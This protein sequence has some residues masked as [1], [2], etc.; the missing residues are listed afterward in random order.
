MPAPRS[1]AT[2]AAGSRRAVVGR[3]VSA[4]RSTYSLR[5]GAKTPW[6]GW[7]R[8]PSAGALEVTPPHQGR[9]RAGEAVGGGGAH[10]VVGD[11][12]GAGGGGGAGEDGVVGW[13]CVVR[14]WS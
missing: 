10:P 13:T 7:T 14:V 5:V 8:A 6:W 12:G 1:N 11:G 9:A 3:G 2:A 4:T